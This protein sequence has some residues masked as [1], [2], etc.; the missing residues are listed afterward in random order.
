MGG[1]GIATAIL[2]YLTVSEK[3]ADFC[4]FYPL[5]SKVVVSQRLRFAQFYGF[6][7]FQS[8]VDSSPFFAS[9]VSRINQSFCCFVAAS[10][11]FFLSASESTLSSRIEVLPP[12]RKVSLEHSP[13]DSLTLT[14]DSIVQLLLACSYIESGLSFVL[15]TFPW[16]HVLFPRGR[17]NDCQLRLGP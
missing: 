6:C 10:D 9:L 1:G 11:N 2:K 7:H 13:S 17:E 12:F 8:R 14:S 5:L 15:E 3:L 16:F 4:F